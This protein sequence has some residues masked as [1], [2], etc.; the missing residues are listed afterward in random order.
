MKELHEMVKQFKSISPNTSLEEKLS[1]ICVDDDRKQEL[2]NTHCK[3][4]NIPH[5]YKGENLKPF[6]KIID[7]DKLVGWYRTDSIG[8]SNWLECLLGLHKQINFDLYKNKEEFEKFLYSIK[9]C[10][11]L[12]GLPEVIE[13]EGEYFIGGNG[14]HRLTIAK[15]VGIKAVPVIVTKIEL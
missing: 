10:D 4:C 15:C 13:Y 7:L 6:L 14:K 8:K 9:Y 5:E 12:Y 11:E 3:Q 2:I 1:S